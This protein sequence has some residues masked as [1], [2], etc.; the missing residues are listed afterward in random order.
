MKI[1]ILSIFNE[2]DEY[3]IM[4]EIQKRYIHSNDLID[5]YF[6][7]CKENMNS[8]LEVIDD[9]IYIK[10]CENYMTI[11]EKTIIAFNYLINIQNNNYDYVVRT[12]VSTLINYKLLIKY[13]ESIPRDNI[14]IGGVLFSLDWLDYKYGITDFKINL[15]NLK[16]MLFFQGTG[17]IMSC[18]VIKFILNNISNLKY[19]IVDDVAIGLLLRNYLPN[20]YSCLH[21]IERPKYSVNNYTSDSIIIRNNFYNVN[22]ISEIINMNDFLNK[23]LNDDTN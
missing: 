23:M 11:L 20:A 1:L 19:D 16:N 17:I 14:Y 21:K 5:Y 18:D 6:V 15:Y 13:L 9:I 10:S 22:K 3:K 2:S 12:N 4:K 8:E 7:T